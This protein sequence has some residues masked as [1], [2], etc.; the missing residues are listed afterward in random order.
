M[1]SKGKGMLMSLMPCTDPLHRISDPVPRIP[2]GYNSDT[3]FPDH[4]ERLM[5]LGTTVMA[6]SPALLLP[7]HFHR[8]ER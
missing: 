6:N 5:S 4:T 8:D 7:S 1:H 3:A 2:Y